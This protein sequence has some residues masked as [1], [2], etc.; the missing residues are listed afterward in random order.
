MI[1]KL[2]HAIVMVDNEAVPSS[3]NRKRVFA[4]MVK[5]GTFDF[6][7]TGLAFDQLLQEAEKRSFIE[8]SKGSRPDFDIMRLKLV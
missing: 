8:V 2:A 4:M 3:C 5:T 6:S 1:S 7:Q